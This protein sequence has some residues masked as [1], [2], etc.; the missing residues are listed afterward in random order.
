MKDPLEEENEE[1]Q[2]NNIIEEENNEVVQD[3]EHG[4]YDIFDELKVILA[5][6]AQF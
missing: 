5:N 4:L 1:T 6:K 3:D 2:A